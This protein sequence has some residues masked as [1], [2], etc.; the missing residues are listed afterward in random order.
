MTPEEI[1][2]NDIERESFMKL[3]KFLMSAAYGDTLRELGLETNK[4]YTVTA[5]PLS[6]TQHLYAT[7]AD[8]VALCGAIATTR[9]DAEATIRNPLPLAALFICD[10][11]H[12]I[13][14]RLTCAAME[15]KGL[16]VPE[17]LLR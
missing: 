12:K 11:C 15:R 17:G 10:K 16:D 8:A 7:G 14:F 1:S 6:A 9:A 3:V 13:M 4:C 2:K 5:E